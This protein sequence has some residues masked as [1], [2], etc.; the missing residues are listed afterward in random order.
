MKNNVKQNLRILRD[1]T[2]PLKLLLL[3]YLSSF[4]TPYCRKHKNK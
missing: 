3:R 2:D 1:I 4:L